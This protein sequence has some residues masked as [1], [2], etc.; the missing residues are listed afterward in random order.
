MSLFLGLG[1][2]LGDRRANLSRAIRLLEQKGLTVLRIS[3][4]VESPA[5]LPEGA[6]ADWN[7]PYLNLV[8]EAQTPAC[9]PEQ[10]R[11]WI[12]EIQNGMGRSNASRWAPRPMDIDILLWDQAIIQTDTLT[13]P[14]LGLLKRGFV[15]SPLLALEPQL[16][17]PGRP[18]QT[19]LEWSRDLPHHIPLWMGIVN[20]TPDSFSDGGRFQD[21]EQIDPHLDAMTAAGVQILDLGAESTRPDATPLS[22]EAEWARLEPVLSRIRDKY[23]NEHLRPLVSIDTYHPPVAARALELGAD[24][25][26]DVGGLTDPAMCELA[27]SY[28]DHDFIAMHN[29][30]LPASR[31]RLLPANC[32]PVE[33][34]ERWLLT[35]REHWER[36]GL[37]LSRLIFDP[38]IG[39][40]KD[41]LQ[42]QK[43]LQQA[44]RFRNHGL[45]V[46]I[47]HSRKSFMKNFSG[48]EPLNKDMATIGASLNL[49]RQGV[50]IL[51]VHNVP[52]HVAAYRGWTHLEGV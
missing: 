21:W 46:L 43:L 47:G 39:F 11:R 48:M 33:E 27:C 19:L 49:S 26:N 25:I 17:I 37:N 18:D 4:V 1:S 45:R 40:G 50:D 9:D 52:L 20:L 3:P 6:P 31:D 10:L 24:I 36:R 28:P 23:R 51:R 2:N 14:H 44:A 41:G 38:G 7:L 32:D 29:L 12:I 30:G 5:L 42:S 15:L 22:A 13:I 34:V 35:Q 16:R 8:L